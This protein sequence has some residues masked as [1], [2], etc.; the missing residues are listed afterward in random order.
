MS[1]DLLTEINRYDIINTY[2]YKR[3]EEFIL[4]K[5]MTYIAI[6]AALCMPLSSCGDK[7]KS[8]PNFTKYDVDTTKAPKPTD[9]YIDDAV[10]AE[11][12]EVYLAVADSQWKAQYLGN[13]DGAGTTLSYDAGVVEIN[14]NGDYTVSV[15]ADTEGFRYAVSGNSDNK[16]LAAAFL[17][18]MMEID[19]QG[20]GQGGNLY[21][22]NMDSDE[23]LSSKVFKDSVREYWNMEIV[24]FFDQL[25]VQ[26]IN[27]E[28]D[29]AK[30]ASDTYRYLRMIR[31]E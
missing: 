22:T 7:K 24:E 19:A 11:S 26:L 31:D 4:K 14:G 16:E 21:K 15:N 2:H 17:A 13:S 20:I 5:I 30:A 25:I 1:I 18:Y 23:I 3:K 9:P 28:I 8:E 6:A 10:T 29:T 12:G 27:G